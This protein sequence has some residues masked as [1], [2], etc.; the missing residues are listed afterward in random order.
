MIGKLVLVGLLLLVL[1]VPVRA[2]SKAIEMYGGRWPDSTI[3]VKIPATPAWMKAAVL[4]AMGV[5]NQAQEWFAQKYF[6][7]G[8]V[9]TLVASNTGKIVVHFQ[10]LSQGV[11]YCTLGQETVPARY[12]TTITSGRMTLTGYCANQA[13]DQTLVYLVAVHEFGH[14]LGIGH[15]NFEE[16]HD[17]M[18]VWFEPDWQISTL[19]LYAV[20]VLASGSAPS[21]IL[22]LPDTIPYELV[23]FSAIPEFPTPIL[24]LLIPML[25]VATLRRKRSTQ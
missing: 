13:L 7:D 6:A 3:G 17:M 22:T 20:H 18:R 9:Y 10:N 21:Q 11:S 12:G 19:D 2:D 8:K 25:L 14:A 4:D 15:V 16:P 1:I 23:P 5:W 24:A